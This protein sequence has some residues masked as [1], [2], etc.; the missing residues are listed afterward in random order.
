MNDEDPT[1]RCAFVETSLGRLFLVVSAKGIRTL[2]FSESPD[3]NQLPVVGF[4]PHPSRHD[5]AENDPGLAD[6]WLRRLEDAFAGKSR[7][8]LDL[9][10]TSFQLKVWRALCR[11]P[12]GRTRTYGEIARDI[13]NPAAVRAVG[14]ACGANPIAILVP[15]H[16]VL[17]K[18][19]GLGGYFFGPD[20]KRRLLDAESDCGKQPRT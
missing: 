15:C 13:G 6:E 2:R 16:R 11:I 10:G 14:T 19:G 7:P 9:I 1:A 17:R 18:G 12:R 8:E 20:T 3:G 5:V 4:R